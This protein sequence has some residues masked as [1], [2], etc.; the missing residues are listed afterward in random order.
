VIAGYRRMLDDLV[1]ARPA[2]YEPVRCLVGD[3][4]TRGHFARAV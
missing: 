1:A 4:F 2:R 3:A